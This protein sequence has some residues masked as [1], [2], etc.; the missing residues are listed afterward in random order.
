MEKKYTVLCLFSGSG[1]KSLGFKW[2]G[3]RSVGNLDYDPRACADLER[4]V[5]EPATRVNIA[6]LTPAG[7]RRVVRE[8]PDVAAMSAPCVGF[9]GCLA[10]SLA[11][12]DK[13][14]GFND[15]ALHGIQLLL[16]AWKDSPTGRKVPG[17]IVFENVPRIKSRGK[18]LLRHIVG[19]LHK[20][21]YSVHMASHICGEIAEDLSQGRPRFLLV[22]RHMATVNDYLRKPPKHKP[23]P[24]RDALCKLPRPR[25]DTP[26]MHR[27]PALSNRNK[28]R[29]ACIPAPGDWRD[30]PAEVYLYPCGSDELEAVTGIRWQPCEGRHAGKLGVLDWSMPA[31]TAFPAAWRSLRAFCVS[32]E[33]MA[34]CTPAFWRSAALSSR[35]PS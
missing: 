6:K 33:V 9:S 28:L 22:A 30:L 12:T 17:L 15:L 29:L 5:G 13:Y 24:I 25:P 34:T 19:L 23:K 10:E 14:Q 20:S 21:G 11:A 3:F 18:E 4:G 35:A 31:R 7:L 26:G 1:G 16:E 8:C 32:P 27:E 2:A